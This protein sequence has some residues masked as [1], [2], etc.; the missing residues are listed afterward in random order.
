MTEATDLDISP[1]VLYGIVQ[2]AL[3]QVEGLHTVQPPVRVG[4]ILTGRRAKGIQIDRGEDGISAALTVCIDYGVEIPKV[5]AEAQRAVRE[6]VASMTGL[7]VATVDVTVEDVDLK[8]S[9]G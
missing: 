3:D 8:Q 9:G 7:S 2:L 6:A 1:D 5:A 4:E